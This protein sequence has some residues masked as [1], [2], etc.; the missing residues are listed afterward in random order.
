MDCDLYLS[1]VPVLEF[2]KDLLQ[3]GTVIIF[4]DWNC[5][6]ADPDKG[7][8]RAWREF[9]ERYPELGFEELVQTGMQKAFV[10]TGRGI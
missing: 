6:W 10:F 8:R 2:V 1:T 3:K 9:C 4:D 5:F 7:E